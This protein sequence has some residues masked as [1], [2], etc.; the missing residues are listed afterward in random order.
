MID[1][2]RASRKD[3]HVRLAEAQ[4]Y[5]HN[6]FDDLSFIHHALGGVNT[7]DVDLSVTVGPWEWATP[8]YVNG[9]T[10]GTDMTAKIN[11]DLAIAARATGM[12]MASGSVSVALDDPSTAAGFTVIREENPDGF[13]MANIGAGR[14]GDDARRAVDLLHADALQLHINA[15]QEVAM[16]EGGT[17]FSEWARLVEEVVA[18][19]PV[20]VI[21]KEVG[22]GLS[23]RTLSLLR[24]LGVQFADVSG[25]G[26]TDFLAIE[27]TRRDPADHI[28]Y[29]ILSG[30]GHSALACLLD[31]PA[32]APTLLASGG[33][34]N[35]FDV[36]K[37]LSVGGHAVGVAGTFLKA[38]R[39]GGAERL[40]AIVG[41]WQEQMRGI[42]GL[43]GAP[44]PAHLT[45]TDILVRGSLAEF[46]RL[47]NID[48]AALANR[49]AG[50]PNTRTP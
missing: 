48:L 20:P 35:P 6:E 40:I 43:L 13:V 37:A 44:T 16:P 19:S 25:R 14:S 33:V 17:N 24:D 5:D 2:H 45:A 23:R 10:G 22:F 31:A 1:P 42:L 38:V 32:D 7:S 36:V 12:P 28:D 15:V 46:A 39:D 50:A 49:S 26:G 34:R 41:A 27:N 9:M 47:R 8:F 11:R 21:A 18:A 30:I 3:D 4:V 29:S